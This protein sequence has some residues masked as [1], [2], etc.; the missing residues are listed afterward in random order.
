L[1]LGEHKQ[2]VAWLDQAFPTANRLGDHW[3]IAFC[4]NNYGEVARAQGDY[5][6]AGAYYRQAEA[7]Y[8]EADSLSDH[9]RLIHTL[10]YIGLHDGDY[11]KAKEL[12]HQ[13]LIAFRELGNKRGMA[14]CLAGL[15]SVAAEQGKAE[16]ATPLLSAAG[17]Q[18]TSFGAAYWP[19]DRVEVERTRQ[20]LRSV[21][22]ATEFER[23]L[24]QG[25][26]MSLDQAIAYATESEQSLLP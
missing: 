24:E 3:Q 19:A 15:A 14:E 6:T 17:T 5:L 18:L 25:K 26:K 12:F 22:G 1:G 16:W 2:A 4:L 7:L 8:R 21:L 10:G 9:T 11:Q 13:S 20:R 23:L